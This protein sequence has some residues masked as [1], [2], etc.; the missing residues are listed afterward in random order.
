M[1]IRKPKQDGQLKYLWNNLFPTGIPKNFNKYDKTKFVNFKKILEDINLQNVS[2]KATSHVGGM[3]RRGNGS[4][5]KKKEER[6]QK[7][8]NRR[9]KFE[10]EQE[11]ARRARQKKRSNRKKQYQVEKDERERERGRR[12]RALGKQQRIRNLEDIYAEVKNALADA[13]NAKNAAQA[14]SAA[15]NNDALASTPPAPPPPIPPALANAHANALG[16]AAQALQDA[17]YSNAAYHRAIADVVAIGKIVARARRL[18]F[19]NNKMFHDTMVA[20]GR[21]LR[22]RQVAINERNNAAHQAGIA[23]AELAIAAPLII[24]HGIPAPIIAPIVAP[25]VAPIAAGSAL[26]LLS[27]LQERLHGVLVFF[28]AAAPMA[29][30]IGQLR[31]VQFMLQSILGLFIGDM[32]TLANFQA[33]QERLR[34]VLVFFGAPA[35]MASG[36]GQLTRVQAALHSIFGIFDLRPAEAS[37]DNLRAVQREMH[38]IMLMFTGMSLADARAAVT[39]PGYGSRAVAA[40]ASTLRPIAEAAMARRRSRY[41]LPDHRTVYGKEAGSFLNNLE[42]YNSHLDEFHEYLEEYKST[43]ES[44][45]EN[46]ASASSYLVRLILLGTEDEYNKLS[47][48]LTSAPESMV[49]SFATVLEREAPIDENHLSSDVLTALGRKNKGK[50]HKDIAD[51]VRKPIETDDEEEPNSTT[52]RPLRGG[53]TFKVFSWNIA[54]DQG[55]TSIQKKTIKKSLNKADILAFQELYQS[56]LNGYGLDFSQYEK[57]YTKSGADHL[58]TFINKTLKPKEVAKGEFESGRPFFINSFTLDGKKVLFINVHLGHRQGG[59]VNTL[60]DADLNP[61]KTAIGS[62]TFDRLMLAGDFNCSPNF[63]KL[64]NVEAKN[65]VKKSVRRTTNTCCN[66][67]RKPVKAPDTAGFIDNVLDS[68]YKSSDISYKLELLWPTKANRTTPAKDL[69]SD[70]S[71]ILATLPISVSTTGGGVIFVNDYMSYNKPAWE[72]IGHEFVEQY[73]KRRRTKGGRR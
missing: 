57:Y 12:N 49:H 46:V 44:F 31:R 30:G 4:R 73:N 66:E 59:M 61:L 71:P 60:V 67:F 20:R 50:K 36:L 35:P 68:Y 51:P 8:R 25:I 28:G 26:N 58:F 41:G 19:A 43:K 65:I 34:G 9:E 10:R 23:N 64:N 18:G 32:A 56:R 2:S 72:K 29:S 17:G 11:I 21:I 14:S 42:L 55:S 63:V 70:H 52:S 54:H 69:G 53:G 1:S 5:K 27:T 6:N 16:A 38:V 7:R 15:A 39:E 33:L 62:K 48:G 37:L 47:K 45:L 3:K 24:A 22:E 13:K 40:I